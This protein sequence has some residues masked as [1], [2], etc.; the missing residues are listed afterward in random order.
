MIYASAMSCR[1]PKKWWSVFW[2]QSVERHQTLQA[3]ISCD[4]CLRVVRR[5]FYRQPSWMEGQYYL[6]TPTCTWAQWRRIYRS[7]MREKES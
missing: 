7:W 3:E 2:W 6:N 1:H 5:L 4:L